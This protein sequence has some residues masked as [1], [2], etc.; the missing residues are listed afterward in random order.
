MFKE[1]GGCF[2]RLMSNS[3]LDANSICSFIIFKL[4]MKVGLH[5]TTLLY[6]DHL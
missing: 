6:V 5:S 4:E 3:S 1:D 2:K